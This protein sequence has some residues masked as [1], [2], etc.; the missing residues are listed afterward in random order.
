MSRRPYA[1]HKFG[2]KP[3][4]RNGIRFDSKLEARLYD[5]LELEKKAGSVLFFLR[6]VGIHLPGGTRL[7]VDFQVFYADGTVR[8][9]D[10][11]GTETDAFKIKRREVE[12]AYPFE[13]ETWPK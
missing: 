2:A 13:I 12:A 10:A 8:F 7:V 9:L 3:T 11:K 1:R 5:E 6:Q 4:V